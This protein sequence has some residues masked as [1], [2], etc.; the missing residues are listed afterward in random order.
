MGRYENNNRRN[1]NSGLSIYIGRI[2]LRNSTK[3]ENYNSDVSIQFLESNK[4]NKIKENAN[5]QL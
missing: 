2:S 4:A 3:L 5:R 1:V